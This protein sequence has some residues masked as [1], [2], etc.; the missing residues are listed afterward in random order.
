[1]P[2]ELS[3]IHL[4]IGGLVPIWRRKRIRLGEPIATAAQLYR[5]SARP[6]IK[7]EI[8]FAPVPPHRLFV[9]RRTRPGGNG[10]AIGCLDHDAGQHR[11]P[12]RCWDCSVLALKL[13]NFALHLKFL[14]DFLNSQIS[15]A[16][17]LISFYR[18]FPAFVGHV[19]SLQLEC[20][21][22][23]R[24][25]YCIQPAKGQAQTQLSFSPFL[26]FARDILRCE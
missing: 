26:R 12:S 19:P 3:P 6:P 5:L 8:S 18:E 21:I 2:S 14:A 10:D 13:Q 4:P 25:C 20:L 24:C 7:S 17:D 23:H 1:M 15:L 22:W 11:L 9:N 16:G